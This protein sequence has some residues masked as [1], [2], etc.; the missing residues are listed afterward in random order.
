MSSLL[1]NGEVIWQAS[2]SSL[3][4]DIHANR[5]GRE[6]F[7]PQV[8]RIKLK[9]SRQALSDWI[10]HMDQSRHKA[11]LFNYLLA[12]SAIIPSK[13]LSSVERSSSCRFFFAT[14]SSVS[15]FLS[16]IWVFVMWRQNVNKSNFVNQSKINTNSQLQQRFCLCQSTTLTNMLGLKHEQWYQLL[17]I[18]FYP[19][20]LWVTRPRYVT[21]RKKTAALW[22]FQNTV[23]RR[24][25]PVQGRWLFQN[26]VFCL[27]SA[28][29]WM[30]Y[31]QLKETVHLF[32]D[33]LVSEP[34]TAAPSDNNGC[35]N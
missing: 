3:T 14:F 20:W 2:D 27:D 5:Y 15:I 4:K 24:A 18:C 32:N 22:T 11:K 21:I 13:F 17:I 12:R 25:K 9:I 1:V 29:T 33:K 8:K 26:H 35:I 34:P 10:W 7:W 30:Y 23:S 31:K 19:L 16:S 6:I 28:W